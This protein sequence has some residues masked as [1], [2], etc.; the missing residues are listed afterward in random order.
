MKKIGS[1]HLLNRKEICQLGGEKG[2]GPALA[3]QPKEK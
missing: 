3:L 1:D 2:V